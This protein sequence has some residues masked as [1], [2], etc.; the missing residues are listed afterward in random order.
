MI[1]LVVATANGRR[2]AAHLE[3]VWSDARLYQEKPGVALR[4][5]WRECDSI[6]LFLAAGAAVRLV[7]PL[8]GDK[9]SDPGVVCVDD[10]GRF[11]VALVGGHAGGANALAGRVAGALGATPVITTASD[12]VGSPALDS[13][14]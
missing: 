5:A 7:S 14:G 9:R 11:A 10:A 2:N 3:R 6:V 1:G 8:L 12:A 13:L 4:R